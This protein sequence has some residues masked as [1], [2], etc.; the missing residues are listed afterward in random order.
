[1][2]AASPLRHVAFD[3]R[4]LLEPR[5]GLR[6]Y[7]GELL[8]ELARAAPG[9]TWTGVSTSR[10]SDPPPGPF[11]W[12]VVPGPD[13]SALRFAWEGLALP[14]ALRALGPDVFFSPWGAVPGNPRVPVVATLHDLAFLERPGSLPLRHR[15]YWNRVARRLPRATAVIAVSE[16]TRAA[17]L[18]RLPLDPSRV[19]VVPEA[20]SAAFRPADPARVAEARSRHSLDGRYVLAVGAF[21]PRKNLETA[22]AAA[23]L[24]ARRL[25]APLPLAVVGRE[26]AGPVAGAP[27][28]RRLG[29]LDDEELA[30]L[31]TAAAA[32]LVPSL[33]EGFG[34]PVLEAMA[35][36]AP[37]IASRAGALPEVAG[38][39]ALLL[40]PLDGDAWAE[41]VASVA[42]DEALSGR[43]RAAGPVRAALFSWRAAA[44]ATLEVLRGA[45][46]APA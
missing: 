45:A 33:D 11:R 18:A 31:M 35:C 34:L 40:D 22:V 5:G 46:G 16:A 26:P 13:A 7:L 1:M 15:L 20:P 38:D 32:V 27:H 19:R 28:A 8:P 23:G 21:E 9:V 41:A 14:A 10:P 12:E 36:G 29:P 2:N 30:A 44:R 24:A 43:L 3:A 42:A 37:V 39:A 6:R 4:P 17:A 25:A